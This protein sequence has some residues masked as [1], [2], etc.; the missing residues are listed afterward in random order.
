ME[1]LSVLNGLLNVD[2]TENEIIDG[3]QEETEN[4]ELVY[5]NLER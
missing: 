1:R 3:G 4:M 5:K 2:K